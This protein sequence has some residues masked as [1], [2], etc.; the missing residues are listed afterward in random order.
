MLNLTKS[1]L[2]F[3]EMLLQLNFNH[4]LNNFENAEEFLDSRVVEIQEN[5]SILTKVRKELNMKII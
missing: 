5:F 2:K 4:I 3:L 1:E